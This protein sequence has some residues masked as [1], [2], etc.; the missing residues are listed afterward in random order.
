MYETVSYIPSTSYFGLQTS[1]TRVIQTL[2]F[3]LNIL[4]FIGKIKIIDQKMMIYLTLKIR[5][6]IKFTKMYVSFS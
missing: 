6:K 1:E 2:G 3:T 5:Q 4:D